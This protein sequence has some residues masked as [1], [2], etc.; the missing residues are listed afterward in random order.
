MHIAVSMTSTRINLHPLSFVNSF[1]LTEFSR[2]AFRQDDCSL[3]DGSLCKSGPL[4]S[5]QRVAVQPP[6][7]FSTDS[8]NLERDDWLEQETSAN[9]LLL[10]VDCRTNMTNYTLAWSSA[11]GTDIDFNEPGIL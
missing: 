10:A 4:F 5:P 2:V 8:L 7:E 3:T 9:Q 1:D 6:V 11:S